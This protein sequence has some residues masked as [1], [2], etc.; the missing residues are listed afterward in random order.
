MYT[1]V[2]K[3]K[4]LQLAIEGKLVP[5]NENDEPIEYAL[6]ELKL[7]KEE[8]IS[9]KIIKKEKYNPQIALNE[10]LPNGWAYAKIG[11]I[12]SIVTKQTGFDYSKHIKPNLENVKN[13]D[14]IP[15]I[16]TKNFTG[17]NFN[18]NTD[19]YIPNHIAKNFPKILLNQKCLLLSIV[20]ASIGNLGVFNLDNT[21]FLGGAI[22]K[23]NLL[24]DRFYDYIYYFLQSSKGQV[25][26]K[27][28]YKSTAQGTITVQDVREIIVPLPPLEEQKRIVAK[29]DSLFKLI[30]ELDSNKRDL[31]QNISDARKKVLQLAI[32]GKLV[33]QNESD[34]PASVLL[35]KIKSEKEQLIKDKI[36][37]KEKPFQEITDNEKLFDLPNGWKWCRFSDICNFKIGKTPQRAKS[38]YWVEGEIPWVS[39]SDLIDGKEITQTKEKITE[40]ADLE[41]FKGNISK[42]GTL[43]MSF[44][45]SIGKISLLGMNAYHNEAI[46]SIYPYYD[47]EDALKLYLFKIL[48]SL[49]LL[50]DTKSAVKGNTLNSESIRNILIPLPPI[51]EQ[52]RIVSKLNVIMNYL[53][54]LEKE[55][56]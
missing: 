19:Y 13:D 2:L 40:K 25:E 3:N 29:V 8:L 28:N 41:V 31:L 18:T 55:I 16:Q 32:Q 33:S 39:I 52:K 35:G 5:Q 27:K 10:N 45:L 21:C 46:I 37:K 53:D 34:E 1:Q 48:P 42:K 22:C 14:N 30:D 23:V 43:L 24:D 56:K 20:G 38:E 17:Y 12:S 7:K 36:I 15:M 50:S 44:K 51:E 9:N 6:E 26:I 49:D 54:I 11:D 47:C 4:V